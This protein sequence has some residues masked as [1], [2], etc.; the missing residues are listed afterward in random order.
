VS[1]GNTDPRPVARIQAHDPLGSRAESASLFVTSTGAEDAGLSLKFDENLRPSYVVL[2]VIY[3]AVVLAIG[4]RLRRQMV[5]TAEFFLAGR[6]MPAWV[7][8]LAF[9]SASG[10][11]YGILTS[12]FYWVGA[13]PAMAFVGVFMM[14]FYYDRVPAVSP[15]T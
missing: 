2:I 14:P 6:S 7:A 13:I 10:A 3:C 11:K 5:G 8:G 9:L 4:V 15:N 1:A 12:H